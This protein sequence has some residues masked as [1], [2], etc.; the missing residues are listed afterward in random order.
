MNDLFQIVI[1]DK[2]YTSQEFR[3][4]CVQ[5]EITLSI[6]SDGMLDTLVRQW[7]INNPEETQAILL[8]DGEV[9][10]G[11]K[12]IS[13]PR[14]VHHAVNHSKTGALYVNR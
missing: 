11:F 14:R 1:G 3:A 10:G 7:N 12:R 6:Y 5:E 13:E 8:F 4:L 2:S 9:S